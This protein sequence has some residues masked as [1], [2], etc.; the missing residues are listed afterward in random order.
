MKCFFVCVSVCL[1]LCMYVV[2]LVCRCWIPRLHIW[3]CF[4][5]NKCVIF[6]IFFNV[7]FLWSDDV[8]VSRL[9]FHAISVMHYCIHRCMNTLNALHCTG[10]CILSNN[11]CLKAILIM[12]I[13]VFFFFKDFS[14]Q[15]FLHF[16]EGKYNMLA[17]YVFWLT[18]WWK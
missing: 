18:V 10:I 12:H 1:F 16:D 7:F 6:I 5:E 15:N 17:N 2:V 11:I 8:T 14:H 9:M 13:F 4:C 3:C